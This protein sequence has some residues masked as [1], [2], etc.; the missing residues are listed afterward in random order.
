MA[1]SFTDVGLDVHKDTVAVALPKRACGER[2]ASMADPQYAC[3]LEGTAVKQLELPRGPSNA[4][5]GA[6][7]KTRSL[8]Q[9]FGAETELCSRAE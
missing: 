6:R 1:K 9:G 4:A 2:C 5:A 8:Q 7:E 3:R